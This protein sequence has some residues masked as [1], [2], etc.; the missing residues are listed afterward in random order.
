MD[1]VVTTA[2]VPGRPAPRLV[3][4][5]MLR[6]MRPAP[7]IV[8]L[9]AESGGN[10]EVTRAGETVREGGVT[11]P[12]AGEP[13]LHRPP[14]REPDSTAGTSSTSSH[15]LAP[16]GRLVGSIPADEIAGPMLGRSTAGRSGSTAEPHAPPDLE[17]YVFVLA[18]FVG[19][20]R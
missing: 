7:S 2:Q 12:R 20:F 5:E 8:D 15:H 18:G 17:L 11:R 4:A 1:L 13:P 16:E 6:A 9:A 3:T 14:P 19:L 10:C